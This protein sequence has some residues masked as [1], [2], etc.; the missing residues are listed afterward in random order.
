[1]CHH[2]FHNVVNLLL[3]PL[4]RTG[5][6]DSVSNIESSKQ[7][8][9]NEKLSI[10]ETIDPRCHADDSFLKFEIMRSKISSWIYD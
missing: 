8:T 4:N 2:L 1:M 5:R 6:Y 3:V 9:R 7:Q 10:L